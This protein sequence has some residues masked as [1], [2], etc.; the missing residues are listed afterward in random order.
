MTF[1]LGQFSITINFMEKISKHVPDG[2][3]EGKWNVTCT[4][5]SIILSQ[6][7]R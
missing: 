3:L 2:F 4:S 1:A 7:G 6:T 5:T